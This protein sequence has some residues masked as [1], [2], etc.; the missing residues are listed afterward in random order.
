MNL[1]KVI[2]KPII[3]E[4]SISG[5]NAQNKYFFEV[6]RSASKGLIKE[7]VENMFGIDV[8]DVRTSIVP[9]KKR[10]I[11]RT[12]KFTKLPAWKKAIVTVA[13]GQEI[14]LIKEGK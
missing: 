4:K 2:K 5:Q 7:A 3:T 6:H 1:S 10:R 13:E 14:K 11:L 12:R 9:G 8:V